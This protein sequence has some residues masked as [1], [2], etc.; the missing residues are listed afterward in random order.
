MSEW[1]MHG[2]Q[3]SFLHMKD[4]FKFEQ[5]GEQQLM[6]HLVALLYN[7]RSGLVGINQICNTFFPNLEKLLRRFILIYISAI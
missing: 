3:G 1:G 4:H 6:L 5:N 7:A 2:F